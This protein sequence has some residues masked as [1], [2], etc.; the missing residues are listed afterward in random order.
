LYEHVVTFA[1]VAVDPD[2]HLL[3]L[4]CW[5]YDERRKAT[6][7][8]SQF[9]DED[10]DLDWRK[11]AERFRQDYVREGVKSAPAI[12]D[13]ASAAAAHWHDLT[14][15]ELHARYNFRGM[16]PSIYRNFSTF[17]HPTTMGLRP[18]VFGKPG[19][20][21]VGRPIVPNTRAISVAPLLFGLA[22][23]V[24]NKV[25]GWP[26]QQDVFQAFAEAAASDN[27]AE[28]SDG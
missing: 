28:D 2:A 20:L 22:L 5:E 25:L 3:R 16:Y 1:W 12:Q 7:D 14:N 9:G 17:A 6:D 24:A 11:E 4:L 19:A 27:D 15:R 23:L 10:H 18:F 13:R 26:E 8:L 21:S